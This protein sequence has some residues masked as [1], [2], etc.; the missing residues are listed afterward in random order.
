MCI[1]DRLYV[2]DFLNF[3]AEEK[4]AQKDET[5]EEALQSVEAKQLSFTYPNGTTGLHDISFLAKKGERLS[6]I[7]I[8]VDYDVWLGSGMVL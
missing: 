6:L 1:R 4:P 3:F 8:S 5:Q 2:E 7:H